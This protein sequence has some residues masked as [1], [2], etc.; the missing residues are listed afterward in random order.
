MIYNINK[1][2]LRHLVHKLQT[3][4]TVT[5]FESLHAD[6]VAYMCDTW[7]SHNVNGGQPDKLQHKSN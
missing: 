7:H 2:L 6:K 1:L 3:Q 4:C 5:V